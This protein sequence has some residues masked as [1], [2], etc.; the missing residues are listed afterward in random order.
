M[1]LHQSEALEPLITSCINGN[2]RAQNELYK[3]AFPY[4]MNVAL[5]YANDHDS[6][7]EIVNEAFFKVF[8]YLKNYDA[9]LSFAAWLRRIVINTAV[10]HYH[11]KQKALTLVNF[12]NEETITDQDIN[13][14]HEQMDAHELLYLI[15]KLPPA[16]RMVLSLFAIE[17]YSHKEIS[18]QLQIAEGTSKSNYH[19]AKAYLKKMMM[20]HEASNKRMIKP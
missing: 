10:D 7:V 6:S 11:R 14:V 5:R 8:Q 3:L 12:P 16:Y 4:A 2:R 15:Q 18:E 19:K 20:E 1:N 17:G 13:E 9:S